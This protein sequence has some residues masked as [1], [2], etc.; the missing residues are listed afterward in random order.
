MMCDIYR[1]QLVS[2]LVASKPQRAGELVSVRVQRQGEKI[3]HWKG[4]A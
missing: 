3:D 4:F 2:I 1:V